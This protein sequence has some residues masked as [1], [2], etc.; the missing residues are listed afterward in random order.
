MNYH[1]YN[2]RSNIFWIAA[3][4]LGLFGGFKL[5]FAILGLVL[6][7]IINF[8]P[9][10]IGGF[11]L[12]K[13]LNR[14]RHQ[15]NMSQF[16]Q[17]RSKEHQKFVE[18]FVRILCHII[19][20]DGKVSDQEKIAV[21]QF[22]QVQLQFNTQQ[23]QWVDDL[24]AHSLATPSPLD[25]VCMELQ[26]QFNYQ[27][28]VML[29]ELLYVV[30]LS[31]GIYHRLEEELIQTIVKKLHIS[32]SDHERIRQTHLPKADTKPNHYAI[33]GLTPSA[34]REEIKKAYRKLSKEYHPD[35]VQHLGKEFKKVAEEKMVEINKA[36]QALY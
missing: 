8:L 7:I 34:S 15:H 27:S 2:N 33:L 4:L 30:A 20:A 13:L 9:L 23:L 17:T 28:L 24:I 21:K 22:F 14:G 3:I 16:V 35:V 5:L 18:L 12:Y 11:L 25:E 19:K 6:A 10:I 1:N 32:S 31:D 26:N 36:Y 29:T